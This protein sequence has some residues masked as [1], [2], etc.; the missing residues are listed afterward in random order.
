MT[1]WTSY[2][3]EESESIVAEGLG[4]SRC[5]DGGGGDNAKEE[6]IGGVNKIILILL[7]SSRRQGNYQS[8]ESEVDG[9]PSDT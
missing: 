5:G 7:M 2:S 8:H 6:P 1:P 3:L 9:D 4:H